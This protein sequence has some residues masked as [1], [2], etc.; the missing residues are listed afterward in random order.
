MTSAIEQAIEDVRL[1]ECKYQLATTMV[2]EHYSRQADYEAE[3]ARLKDA[4]RL[5]GDEAREAT[6]RLMR[7]IVGG[8]VVGNG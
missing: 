5:A 4:R 2:H 8:L 6:D 7:C 1:A 3:L